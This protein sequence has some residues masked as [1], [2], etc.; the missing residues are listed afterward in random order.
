ME[1]A[2][3]ECVDCRYYDM[4]EGICISGDSDMLGEY[5]A[6]CEACDEYEEEDE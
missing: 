2:F 6:G 4:W 1:E 5:V 3:K